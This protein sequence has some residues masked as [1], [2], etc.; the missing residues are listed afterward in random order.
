[1][2][3]PDGH[4]IITADNRARLTYL[5]DPWM[6]PVLSPFRRSLKAVFERVGL[7]H[8]L[9][10]MTR[11]TLHSLRFIDNVL[12]SVGLVKS[13]SMTL[14]FG[15][16]SFLRCNFIPAPFSIK[17]HRWLQ[18]LA[19]RKVPIVRTTGTQYLVMTTKARSRLRGHNER[20]ESDSSA[21]LQM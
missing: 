20:Q 13:R 12:A 19:D 5:L 9:P 1:V 14:G 16:F 3:R 18:R 7:L 8:R 21:I 15:P 4:V 17:L 6:N 2:T 11:E 10:D